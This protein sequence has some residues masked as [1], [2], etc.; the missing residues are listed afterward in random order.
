MIQIIECC[1]YLSEQSPECNPSGMVS[2]LTNDNFST[3][4][5]A[6]VKQKIQQIQQQGEYIIVLLVDCR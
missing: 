1:Q 6:R 4:V 3:H 5:S 2:L